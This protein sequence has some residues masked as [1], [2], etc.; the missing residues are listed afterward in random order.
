MR[1]SVAE[2]ARRNGVGDAVERAARA[3]REAL[4]GTRDS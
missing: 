1:E 3:T 2:W 4:A